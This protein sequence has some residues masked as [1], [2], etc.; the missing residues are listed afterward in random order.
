MADYGFSSPAAARFPSMVVVSITN[1]CDFSCTHCFYPRYVQF[2]GYHRNDM[3]MR[4][5]RVI[6]DEMGA[7][8]GS[9]LRLI[10]WG[11]PLCHPK[12]V[13][14]IACAS[15]AAGKCPVTLITNG[16]RMPP[17]RS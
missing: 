2:P 14:L 11:E 5:F 3:E 4:V 17:E 10:A 7:Y 6:A 16:Y 12:L 1:A 15:T 9:I 8:P 13:D